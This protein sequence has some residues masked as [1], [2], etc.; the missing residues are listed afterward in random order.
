MVPP[1]DSTCSAT[2]RA[3]WTHQA[4]TF[5]DVLLKPKATIAATVASIAPCGRQS[6]DVV[7]VKAWS[8]RGS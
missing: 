3:W 8:G 5:G 4:P 1:R 7:S 6:T 2:P